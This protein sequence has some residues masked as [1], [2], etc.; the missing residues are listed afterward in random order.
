MR[1]YL[2]NVSLQDVVAQ[3]QRLLPVQL[4]VLSAEPEGHERVAVPAE[5]D[6]ETSGRLNSLFLSQLSLSAGKKANLG[7]QRNLSSWPSSR[8]ISHSLKE[9]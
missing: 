8:H 7:S 1:S 5:D 6:E 9:A 3:L 4:P 2:V